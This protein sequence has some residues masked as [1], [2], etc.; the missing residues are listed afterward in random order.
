MPY[1]LLKFLEVYVGE[2]LACTT[3]LEA[4]CLYVGDHFLKTLCE[5]LEI[6]LIKENHV[7]VISEMTV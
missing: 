7:F 4:L 2:F 1:V 6:L 3:V 5:F